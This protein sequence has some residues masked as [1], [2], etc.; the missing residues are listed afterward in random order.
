MK[1]VLVFLSLLLLALVL[2][3]ITFASTTLYVNGVAG[4]DS[5]DC[6]L[7]QAACKTIEHA[8][9]LASS[10]DSII[11]ASATYYEN[12]SIG[13][14][15]NV[16][17]SGAR[18]TIIN[19]RCVNTVVTISDASAIVTLSNVTVSNGCARY[20]G[21]ISNRGVLKI[22]ASTISGNHAHGARGIANYGQLTLI[23]S[24]L[25]GNTARVTCSERCQARGGGIVNV[26]L[27]TL[28]ITNSTL[29]GNVASTICNLY[30]GSG[31]GAIDNGGALIIN[32]STLSGNAARSGGAIANDSGYSKVTL[33]N[34][35]LANNSGGE[36]R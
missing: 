18:T 22:I 9:A 25:Y 17:G 26:I 8:I 33:Q 30:C 24:T 20:A 16:I 7:E 14:S 13:I 6:L 1:N 4:N 32:S 3:P 35:I 11:V 29:S 34:S 28:T 31:G 36:L 10:G 15:L 2:A 19:G 5:N 27:A 12:L 21:G 23:N